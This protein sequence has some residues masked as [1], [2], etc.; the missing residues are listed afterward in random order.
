MVLVIFLGWLVW[1]F[2]NCLLVPSGIP[3]SR[4]ATTVKLH[5]GAFVEIFFFVFSPNCR[6][7]KF[8]S[9][10]FFALRWKVKNLRYSFSLIACRAV[11]R[12]AL[13]KNYINKPCGWNACTI[14][15]IGWVG[16][17]SWLSWA[18]WSNLFDRE[19]TLINCLEGV[20][21]FFRCWLAHMNFC[22]I[23]S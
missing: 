10:K 1:P 7:S 8:N 20:G 13:R 14:V 3:P 23:K 19:S 21:W 15:W 5:S 17:F 16:G 4:S 6:G 2:T 12:R 18:H 9:I 11:A 22:S